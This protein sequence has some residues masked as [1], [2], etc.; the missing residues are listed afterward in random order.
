VQIQ[1]GASPQDSQNNLFGFR[2]SPTYTND[3]ISDDI[4]LVQEYAQSN[5][6]QAFATLVSQH[7]NLVYSVAIRQVRDP[8]LAEE[9][10]QSVFIIL[11]EKAKSLGPKTILSSW[12]CR[13][14]RYVSANTL[15]IQRRRQFREQKAHMESI[16]NEPEP[17]V[18]KQIAPLLDDALNR[19]GEKEHDAVVLRFFD[20]KELKQVGAAMG[21]TEDAAR[22]RV[23]RGV[24]RLRDFFTKRG[25]TL[26]ATAIAG[27][28]AANSIQAAP[29]GLAATITAVALAG[30]T[31]TTTTAIIAATKTIAMTTLQKTVIS[32]A[33]AVAVGTGIYTARQAV[34]LR[35]KN[36]TLQ[37]ERASL[38]EQVQQLQGERDRATNRLDSMAEEIAQIKNH[39]SELLRLRGEVAR[40]RRESQEL[41]KLKSGGALGNPASEDESWIKRIRSLKQRVEQTPEAI[42]PELQ[43]LTDQDWMEA[44]RNRLETAEDYLR[45][46]DDVRSR[47]QARFLD[48]A[49]PALQ[50]YL[51]ANSNQFPADVLQLKPY[52]E[53]PPGDDILQHY[54]VAPPSS[55]PLAGRSGGDGW[56]ITPKSQQEG[57]FMA[58]GQNGGVSG[59]VDSTEMRIL[60]PAFQAITDATPMINGRRIV[61]IHQL[62]PYLTTPEQKSAYERLLGNRK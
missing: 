49:G 60:A 43:F 15:S 6:E 56:V 4:A 16:L 12:L 7:V 25:M 61:N 42:I 28:I 38:T 37:Q 33:L 34:D 53:D 54:Q 40:L 52:F 57:T 59:S 58:L 23:N 10:T 24:E 47:A 3:M 19:L 30:T 14:A 5:S 20:G 11:A 55:N 1:P 26:S 44:A 36:Q 35:D 39:N 2:V 22:M 29:A 18:W 13:T 46:L 45:A 50:K 41:A 27:G 31:I 17:G 62:G 51:A 21:I 32:T 48:K 9:I 8:H